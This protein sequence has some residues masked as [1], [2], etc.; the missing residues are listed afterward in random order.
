MNKL[1][2]Y[3]LATL[4]NMVLAVFA[5]IVIQEEKIKKCPHL[6][7]WNY[8]SQIIIVY[9]TYPQIYRLLETQI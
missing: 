4:L 9:K 1:R 3:N 6:K 5:N 8:F 7:K 2:T